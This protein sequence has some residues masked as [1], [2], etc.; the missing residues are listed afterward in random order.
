MQTSRTGMRFQEIFGNLPGR[1]SDLRIAFV[2]FKMNKNNTLAR[3][4]TDLSIDI[5]ARGIITT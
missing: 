2:R 3:N 1:P 5:L 4:V